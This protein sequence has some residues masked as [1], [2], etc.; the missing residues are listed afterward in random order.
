MN[1][2]PKDWRAHAVARRR[3][4]VYIAVL[5]VTMVAA[6]CAFLGMRIARQQLEVTQQHKDCER[7]K[8]LAHSATE[9]AVA[10]MNKQSSGSG[11][12]RHDFT[13]GVETSPIYFGGGKMSFK[14]IDEDGDL[15]DG[16]SDPAWIEGIG[17]VGDAVWVA[18]ARAKI[19]AGIPL[20]LLRTVVHC[21]RT[22]RLDD[23]GLV[24]A[25]GGP[26]STDDQLINDG[27]IEGNAEA[28]RLSGSGSITGTATVPA[29]RKGMPWESTFSDYVSKATQLPY[30]GDIDTVV[31]TPNVNE[32][33]GSLNPD[34]V[35]YL[36]TG[37]ND[38]QIKH[39]RIHGTL[40]IE[41][42]PDSKVVIQDECLIHPYRK[43]FPSLIVKAGAVELK[44]KSNGGSRMLR[45][46]NS[47]NFNPV[48]APYQGEADSDRRDK[49][50][51][52]IQGLVH[53]IADV[54]VE[55]RIW[56]RGCIVVEG[57]MDVRR[58]CQF[59][60]DPDLMLNPPLGY[61][62]DPDSTDMIIEARTWSRRPAP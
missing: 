30:N 10:I 29:E 44:L 28:V 42:G 16:S 24:T 38:L 5:G 12:W 59:I 8:I 4:A 13:S 11:N 15:A 26:V 6:I 49:Y 37:E 20:E 56:V 60:H 50:P 7:A 3:G 34:G 53:L 48:G 22:L 9:R 39:S 62:D 55:E 19:D 2:K 61:T 14:L 58:N 40:L 51:N 54:T 23:G 27:R 1:M 45:E 36:Q 35:Y 41:T 18:R 57:E 17:R 47:H 33:G 43:D 21:S 52:E 46:S 25:S 31:I 32:Y